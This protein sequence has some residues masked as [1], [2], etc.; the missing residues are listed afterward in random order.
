MLFRSGAGVS[1]A[2][3]P[4]YTPKNPRHS[5]ARWLLGA[6][7][8][9][10]Y[11]GEL[12]GHADGGITSSKHYAKWAPRGYVESCVLSDGELVVDLLERITNLHQ[13][14]LNSIPEAHSDVIESA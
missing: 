10:T 12:L 5:L 14:D 11:V 7:I 1:E 6:S 8:P 13:S 9:V 4:R 2:R 3:G